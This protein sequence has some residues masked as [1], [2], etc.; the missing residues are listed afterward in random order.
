VLALGLFAMSSLLTKWSPVTSD[1]GL[2]RA[3]LDRVLAELQS[4]HASIGIEY[5]R[6]GI[7]SSLSDAFESLLPLAHSKMRRLF[8][9]TRSDWVACFQNGI[10]GSDP[11]PAMAHLAKRLEVLAMRVC[12]T[13]DKAKYPAVIWEVYAPESLGG[14]LPLGYRRSIAASNDGGRWVFQESGERFPF[15]QVARY[16]EARKRDRFTS[17]MLRD[18]LRE[19]NVELFADEFLRVDSASPAVC[20]RRTTKICHTPEFTLEQVV[21]GMPWRRAQGAAS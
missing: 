20:L 5:S 10:Q 19:F 18:Y 9:A 13:A 16:A 17:E 11:T 8:V 21:A 6:T 15:E 1:F 2:I 3:P 14:K 4:W 7:T 12:C